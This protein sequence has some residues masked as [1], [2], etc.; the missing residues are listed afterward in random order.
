MEPI[1]E[2]LAFVRLSRQLVALMD[3][4]SSINQDLLGTDEQVSAPLR[5]TLEDVQAQIRQIEAEMTRLQ[6]VIEASTQSLEMT[7][8]DTETSNLFEGLGNH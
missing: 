3:R 7:A 1:A 6:E 4:E 5:A 2:E 8:E